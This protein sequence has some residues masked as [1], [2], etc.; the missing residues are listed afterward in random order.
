MDQQKIGTN[1]SLCGLSPTVSELPFICAII[2][3]ALD[4]ESVYLSLIIGLS[5]TYSDFEHLLSK[6]L[7]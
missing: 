7:T 2:E 5:L 6:Q 3:K 4:L 1:T